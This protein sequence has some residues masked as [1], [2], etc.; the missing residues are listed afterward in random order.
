MRG[1][2]GHSVEH[3]RELIRRELA[4][5]KATAVAE[6]VHDEAGGGERDEWIKRTR[7]TEGAMVAGLFVIPEAARKGLRPSADYATAMQRIVRQAAIVV[8]AATGVTSDDGDKW[9]DAVRSA[10]HSTAAG[11]NLTKRQAK[12]MRAK[13]IATQGPSVTTRWASPAMK[14]EFKRWQQHWRDQAFRNDTEAFEAMPDAI[15]QELKSTVTARR[16]FGRRRPYDP[17]AGGRPSSKAVVDDRKPLDHKVYF[18]KRGNH[19]KIGTSCRLNTR[20]S[21]LRTSTP[22]PLVLIG[23]ID[24]DTK[25]ESAMHQRFAKYRVRGE[26]FKLEGALA[27]Y[28]AKL[29]K[30][31]KPKV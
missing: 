17:S 2:R 8:D 30:I 10:A 24:G 27:K 15:R 13:Q 28:V 26:W 16:V 12:Q 7:P 20:L 1:L 3:Q 19:V 6:Y 31:V 23:V 4:R 11:R 18:I 22:H 14:S 9:D 5:R 25:V 29:P 21:T